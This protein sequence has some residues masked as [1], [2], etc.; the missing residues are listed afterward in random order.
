MILHV[1][2]FFVAGFVQFNFIINRGALAGMLFLGVLGAGIY[3]LGFI[4]IVTFIFGGMVGGYLASQSMS[5][6]KD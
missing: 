3:F 4:S 2:L 5:R 1:I 6:Q